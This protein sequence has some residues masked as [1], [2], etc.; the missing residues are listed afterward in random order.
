MPDSISIHITAPTGHT[1]RS[2]PP[3]P[4]RSPAWENHNTFEANLTQYLASA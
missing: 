3:P 4:P 1:H 2:H